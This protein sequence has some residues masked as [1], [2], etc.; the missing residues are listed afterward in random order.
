MPLFLTV[1]HPFS[2][3]VGFYLYFIYIYIYIFFLLI[4]FPVMLFIIN[5]LLG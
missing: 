1:Y 4:F 3:E 2:N 5:F